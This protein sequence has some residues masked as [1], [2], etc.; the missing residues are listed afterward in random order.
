[1]G[2]QPTY[3][4]I[5]APPIGRYI[6]IR[7]AH[8]LLALSLLG[9]A[10]HSL[11]PAGQAAAVRQRE[12]ALAPHTDAI[13]TAIGQSGRAGA[14]AF[15]DAA[16][17]RLVVLPGDNPGDAWG[18]HTSAPEGDRVR[19]SAPSVLTFLHRGDIPKAPEAVTLTDLQQ[20]QE[21]RRMV[22]T[23]DAEVRGAHAQIE[24]RLG[25]VQRELAAAVAASKQEADVSMAAAR[26]DL[27]K[28]VAALADDL[29][30]V[31]KSLLQTAQLGWLTH[32]TTVENA[33]GLRK[34]A[35]ASQELTASSARLEETVR[36]LSTTLSGQLKE[37]ARRLDNIQG[38]VSSLQ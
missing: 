5:P 35:T 38:K 37:L 13:H 15:L 19:V 18:R 26:A 10:S 9:C 8:L 12:R 28:A 3:G 2:G 31:R 17:G 27:Q 4:A 36:Q 11:M 24:E 22:A 33:S 16:D 1:M 21:L 7:V 23:L 34:V 32:E 30:A 14:L 20:Q 6:P 29:A 25:L